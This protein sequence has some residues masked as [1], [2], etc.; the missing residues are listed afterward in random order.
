MKSKKK[1]APKKT[2]APKNEVAISLV[3]ADPMALIAAEPKAPAPLA[4][5]A[6]PAA[7]PRK[8]ISN[9]ERRRL[10]Q[11]AAYH[12]AERVGFGKTDPVE[13]WLV[14]EREIDAMMTV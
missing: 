5:P 2:T 10:I 12:R 4:P 14:A 11:I 1:A 9:D 13:N 3:K 7:T 8:T 6:P